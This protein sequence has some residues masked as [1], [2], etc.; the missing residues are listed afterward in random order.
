ACESRPIVLKVT[1]VLRNVPANSQLV[2]DVLMPNTSV[3]D[4]VTQEEK[5]N[6]LL[7]WYYSYVTLAPGADPQAVIA[8]LAPILDRGT[9]AALRNFQMSIRGS[10]FYEV[11]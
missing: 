3:A 9:S 7:P 1:G 8:K 4:N 2:A 5:Q 11:R 10:Q 6:W